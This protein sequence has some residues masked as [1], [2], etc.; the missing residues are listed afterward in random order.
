MCNSAALTNIAKA[1]GVNP[2]GFKQKLAI[3]F[4][5]E[6]LSIPAVTSNTLTVATDITYRAAAATPVVILAGS[7]RVFDISSRDQDFMVEPLGDI[8]NP[9]GYKTTFKFRMHS[10]DAASLYS[11]SATAG[12]P[13][14]AVAIGLKVGKNRIIGGLGNAAYLKVIEKETSADGYLDCELTWERSNERPYFYT[15]ALPLA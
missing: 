10:S 15:G 9:S 11:I 14:I 13:M 5:E 6:V 7:M 2:S 8:D 1:C 3:T 12:A 4:E